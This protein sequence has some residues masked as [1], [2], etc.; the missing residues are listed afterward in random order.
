MDESNS[1]WA[2]CTAVRYLHIRGYIE[3]HTL[4]SRIDSLRA[5]LTVSTPCSSTKSSK[6]L[7]SSPSGLNAAS[8]IVDLSASM[9]VSS[10]ALAASKVRMT[11][12][13]FSLSAKGVSTTINTSISSVSY[14]EVSLPLFVNALNPTSHFPQQ[15][16]LFLNTTPQKPCSRTQHHTFLK[17]RTSRRDDFICTPYITD[18]G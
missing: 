3:Q 2:S 12:Y 8:T 5:S 6:L 1:V 14:L 13:K 17:R 15:S 9:V 16:N 11:F 4:D 18:G 7:G 10:L